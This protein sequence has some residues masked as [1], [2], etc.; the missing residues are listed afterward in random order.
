MSGIEGSGMGIR[1]GVRS[2]LQVCSNKSSYRKLRIK[3]K[4]GP[5]NRGTDR[6]GVAL[7]GKMAPQESR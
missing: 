3:S 4:W 5:P 2:R 1:D 6:M 7:E